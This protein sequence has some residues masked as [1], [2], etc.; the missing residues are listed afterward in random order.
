MARAETV[1]GRRCC[2]GTLYREKVVTLCQ[3]GT[4]QPARPMNSSEHDGRLARPSSP[5]TRRC[6]TDGYFLASG[7]VRI[8]ASDNR[9][10]IAASCWNLSG[11]MLTTLLPMPSIRPMSTWI[12]WTLP[13]GPLTT[14]AT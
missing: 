11:V 1:L 14:W 4:R 2:R 12:D 3:A 7:K 8:S 5:N 13:S 10:L 9:S 6:K